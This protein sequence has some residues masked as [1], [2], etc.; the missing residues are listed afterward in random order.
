M[1]RE[2]EDFFPVLP[3]C[4]YRSPHVTTRGC[5]FSATKYRVGPNDVPNGSTYGSYPRGSITFYVRPHSP[6]ASNRAHL[7]KLYRF[8][9]SRSVGRKALL[10]LRHVCHGV[11]QLHLH[12]VMR[13]LRSVTLLRHGGA[14]SGH[15]GSTC[16]PRPTFLCPR[17]SL[18]SQAYP[19]C[20]V[21]PSLLYRSDLLSGRIV[22]PPTLIARLAFLRATSFQATTFGGEE[23]FLFI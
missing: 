18:L 14:C 5:I 15:R 9:A 11:V 22:R 23:E 4:M 7:F 19:Y 6:Y 16:A 10:P 2:I 8:K 13:V 3:I 12:S 20:M 1:F 21:V 17:S